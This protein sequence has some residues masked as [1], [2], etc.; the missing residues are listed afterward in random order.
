MEVNFGL[1]KVFGRFRLKIKQST[2]R[3][4]SYQ[5]KLKTYIEMQMKLRF[6][7]FREQLIH[8]YSVNKFLSSIRPHVLNAHSMNKKNDIGSI[9]SEK[10]TPPS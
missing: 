3:N 5:S 7:I 8:G 4:I 10:S 6:R 9:N 1:L 2:I